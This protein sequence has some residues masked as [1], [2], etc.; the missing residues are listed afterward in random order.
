MSEDITARNI[1][2]F[3]GTNF[4]GWKFQMNML[5]VASGIKDVIDGTRVMPADRESAAGKMWVRDNAKAMFLISSTME[6]DRLEPLLVCVT[7]KDMWD[8]LCR[9][10]EQRSNKLML[11]QKFHE[12]KMASE[13]SV[14]QHMAKIQNMAA[15]LLDLGSS[16]QCNRDGKN[17]G[18]FIAKI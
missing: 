15:Q 16:I 8:K 5:F 17:I 1:K 10:H 12:Y 7:A 18:Q 9:I 2:K 14:V 13:D 6:Y 11:M 3:D 4:Q